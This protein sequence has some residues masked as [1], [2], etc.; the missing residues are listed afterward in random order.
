[1]KN[2]LVEEWVHIPEGGKLTIPKS[3]PL[4]IVQISTKGRIV[5]VKG[6]KG[7]ITKDFRHMP[8]E[9]QVKK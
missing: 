2:I 1:M 8:V 9:L 6:K 4:I 5:T 7:E 3:H